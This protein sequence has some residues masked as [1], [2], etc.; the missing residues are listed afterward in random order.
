MPAS[1]LPDESNNALGPRN[2][3]GG[4]VPTR[5]RPPILPQLPEAPAGALHGMLFR[6]VAWAG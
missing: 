4:P 1:A 6:L 5:P 2:R 3:P